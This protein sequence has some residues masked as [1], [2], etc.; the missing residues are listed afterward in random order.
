M[1]TFSEGQNGTPIKSKEELQLQLLTW[2]HSRKEGCEQTQWREAEKCQ[3]QLW[4]G[5]TSGISGP[6]VQWPRGGSLR[7]RRQSAKA[8]ELWN[9]ALTKMVVW[10]MHL[11]HRLQ[12]S[13]IETTQAEIWVILLH[14]VQWRNHCACCQQGKAQS[15][16]VFTKQVFLLSQLGMF[17][18][19]VDSGGVH[20]PPPPNGFVCPLVKKTA[21]VLWHKQVDYVWRLMQKLLQESPERHPGSYAHTEWIV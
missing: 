6:T 4:N 21:P 12:F 9:L 7:N 17:E 16:S 2:D 5:Q 15:R 18:T 10:Q 19:Q 3:I 8:F 11:L 13:F 20:I 1:H 14:C